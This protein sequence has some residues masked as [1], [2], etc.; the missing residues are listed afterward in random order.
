M[1]LCSAAR[2]AQILKFCHV[3]AQMRYSFV[4]QSS[5]ENIKRYKGAPY[6]NNEND[7]FMI[8]DEFVLGYLK[9]TNSEILSCASTNSILI[10]AIKN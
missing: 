5:N 3:P 2:R 6:K 8:F 9:S 4:Q 1:N 10:C 7:I